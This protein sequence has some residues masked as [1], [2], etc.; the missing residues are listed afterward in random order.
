MKDPRTIEEQAAQ[1]ARWLDEHPGS[2]PPEGVDPDV[3]ETIYALRP[4]LAPA[5]SF[6]IDDI[7][8]EVTTGPFAAIL[9]EAEEPQGAEL[10]QLTPP[11]PPTPAPTREREDEQREPEGVIELA[12][13]RERR[14]P[15]LWSGVGAVAAAAMALIVALPQL[16]DGISDEA[17]Y[18]PLAEQAQPTP[19]ATPRPSTIAELESEL[20]AEPAPPTEARLDRLVQPFQPSPDLPRLA[21]GAESGERGPGLSE[22][23]RDGTG[24]TEGLRAAAEKKERARD[25]GLTSPA[26]ASVAEPPPAGWYSPPASSSSSIAPQGAISRDPSPAPAPS[27]PEP[28]P[29]SLAPIAQPTVSGGAYAGRIADEPVAAGDMAGFV[30]ADEFEDFEELDEGASFD[31]EASVREEDRS[32]ERRKQSE[33][34]LDDAD[35]YRIES[36]RASSRERGEV[37]VETTSVSRSAAG[38]QRGAGRSR[39][40]KARE[41]QA[42]ADDALAAPAPPATNEASLDQL[43]GQAPPMNY[44]AGWYLGDPSIDEITRSQ[45]AAASGQAQ[46]RIAAGDLAGAVGA[47]QPLLGNAHPRVVQEVA[48]RIAE[49]QLQQGQRAAALATVDRGLAASASPGIL[50]RR[51]LHQRGAILEE[52]GDSQGALDA[53]QQAVDT[54]A[55]SY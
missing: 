40:P 48:Y 17:L 50:R 54:R 36:D 46:A 31:L 38:R 1:L 45:L 24:E 22:D 5:P 8:A 53:Y 14:M 12:T 30:A 9:A 4:D 52:L 11:P 15:W 42:E 32:R 35:G 51:L 33:E 7:L 3:L 26:D 47:L 43:R 55:T 21:D 29:E 28:P 39:A 16:R 19:A 49:L 44:A 6:S 2:A 10:V 13:E 25:H 23:R 37:E 20:D 18:A 34:D 41:Q 27:A